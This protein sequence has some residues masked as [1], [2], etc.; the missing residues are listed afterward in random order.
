MSDRLPEDAPRPSKRRWL[1]FEFWGRETAKDLALLVAA[2]PVIAC[3]M[4]V[5]V[6]IV[7]GGSWVRLSV[8]FILFVVIWWSLRVLLLGWV[9]RGRRED[10]A[11]DGAG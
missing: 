4:Y 1:L 8:L 5:P 10:E 9:A 2:I 7:D 11:G 3:L 6:L